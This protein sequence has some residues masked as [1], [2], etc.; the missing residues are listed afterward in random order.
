LAQPGHWLLAVFLLPLTFFGQDSYSTHN[1]VVYVILFAMIA[2][3][4]KTRPQV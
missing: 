1:V 4:L 3:L 2:T